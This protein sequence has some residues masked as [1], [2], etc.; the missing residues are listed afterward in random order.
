MV[1]TEQTN[2]SEIEISIE[3]FFS[4]LLA[5]PGQHNVLK[6]EKF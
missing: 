2:G 6:Y 3:G 5:Q 4:L 1:N